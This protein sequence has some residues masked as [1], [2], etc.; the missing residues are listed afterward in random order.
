VILLHTINY[1]IMTGLEK[2]CFESAICKRVKWWV[3][4]QVTSTDTIFWS[5]KKISS[6]NVYSRICRTSVIIN[7]HNWNILTYC[8]CD[9]LAPRLTYHGGI[10]NKYLLTTLGYIVYQKSAFFYLFDLIYFIL[11][12]EYWAIMN[13]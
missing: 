7:E 6:H 13:R 5:K 4:F 10:S 3:R 9:F 2:R 8:I 1:L 11:S 12:H